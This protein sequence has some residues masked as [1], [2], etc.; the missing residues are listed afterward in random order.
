MIEEVLLRKLKAKAA[1]EGRT[2]QSV[3]NDAMRQGLERT[4]RPSYRLK[5]KGWRAE[6][7]PGVDVTD[8]DRLFDLLDGRG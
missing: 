3:A 8:R 6:L 4:A 5:L 2:L 1:Q 7:Q